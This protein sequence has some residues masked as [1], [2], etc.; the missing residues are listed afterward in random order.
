M[1]MTPTYHQGST[2]SQ[3]VVPLLVVEDNTSTIASMLN[4]MC[5]LG[6]WAYGTFHGVSNPS[7]RQQHQEHRHGNA[8]CFQQI[9]HAPGGPLNRDTVQLRD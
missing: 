2:V 1:S 7:T 4:Q 5:I 8:M 9:V 6:E 3:P